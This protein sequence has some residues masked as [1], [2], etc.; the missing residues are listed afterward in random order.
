MVGKNMEL[1]ELYLRLIRV[2]YPELDDRF[3]S[4]L[5]GPFLSIE[6][7]TDQDPNAPR[8][9]L[10]GKATDGAWELKSFL[11]TNVESQLHERREQTKAFLLSP[12]SRPGFWTLWRALKAETG[13]AVIWS[14]VTK[15]GARTGNPDWKIVQAQADLSI[16]ILRAEIETYRPALLFFVTD[17][18]ARHEIV[19]KLL[20][21][22][23]DT[24]ADSNGIF[25][26][27]ERKDG[28]PA[29]LWTA[30]PGR[31]PSALRSQWVERALDLL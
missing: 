14:N 24:E 9:L 31:K 23:R 20:D 29:V 17:V 4:R 12:K 15:I 10:V 26:A 21:V 7:P 3:P 22:P 8:I 13:G 1:D 28:A 30:H 16:E 11:S 18:F 6:D 27:R 5:A 2:T 25:L 19:S